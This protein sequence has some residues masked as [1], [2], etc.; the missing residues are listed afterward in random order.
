MTFTRKATDEIRERIIDALREAA[1]GVR[2]NSR[3]VHLPGASPA[4]CSS[5]M[6]H[7]DGN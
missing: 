2:R 4:R 7:S 3:I 1:S 5:A 6:R